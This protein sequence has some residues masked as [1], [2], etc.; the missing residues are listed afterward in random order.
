MKAPQLLI[1][2]WPVPAHVKACISTRQGGVSDAPYEGFNLASHVGDDIDSV[3][4]NRTQLLQELAVD[5]V[6]WLEQV[7]GTKLVEA[8]N[9]GRVRTADACY[10]RASGIACAVMT[11]DCLPVLLCDEYGSQVAAVHAGW[12]GLAEGIISET[13]ASFSCAP[14]KL[15]VYLGPAISAR[16]FEVGIDVL[17]AFF[18]SAKSESHLQAVSQSFKPS[19]ALAMKYLADIYALARA[20]F[21]ELG[22]NRVYG[23][24]FCTYS[25]AER[26]Y[27][28]RRDGV[29]GRM[30]SL[31]WIDGSH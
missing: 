28:Y 4:R 14:E 13:V 19:N 12:R 21:D 3:E 8:Q 31:I 11:A 18:E 27:S 23:G 1:P 10:S 24:D 9:D 26:F 2:E 16:A 20:E 5:S 7:H 22:V 6:Q 30:A 15:M 17:E 29:T 25:D